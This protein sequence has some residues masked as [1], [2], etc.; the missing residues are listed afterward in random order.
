MP[1]KILF[2]I[3]K[4]KRHCL[5]LTKDVKLIDALIQLAFFAAPNNSLINVFKN[6]LKSCKII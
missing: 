3:P 5:L 1:D 4:K 6:N 2:E